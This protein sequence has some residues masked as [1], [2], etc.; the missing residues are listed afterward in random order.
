[1]ANY[2]A[3]GM[4]TSISVSISS[5]T[6]SAPFGI[7][8]C[9]PFARIGATDTAGR[10]LTLQRLATDNTTWLDT[11]LTFTTLNAEN[12]TCQWTAEQLAPY[13]GLF[14]KENNLR[15]LLS[16]SDSITVI[17]DCRNGS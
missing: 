11:P 10:T 16:A 14:G 12:S 9:I 3:S 8:N 13:S 4:A 2:A 5:G 7:P 17:F 6:T 1:M 15:L